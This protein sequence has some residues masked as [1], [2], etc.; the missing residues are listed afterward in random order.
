MCRAVVCP[1]RLVAH[2]PG[3]SREWKCF[4]WSRASNLFIFSRWEE[5][6]LMT[7]VLAMCPMWNWWSS[8]QWQHLAPICP[9]VLSLSQ[10]IWVWLS[11]TELFCSIP[12]CAV[13][14]H[15]TLNI[16]VVRGRLGGCGKEEYRMGPEIMWSRLWKNWKSNWGWLIWHCLL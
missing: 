12:S 3:W 5:F 7:A 6:T 11:T 4:W 9:L 16:T 10:A 8:S 2:F 14:K 13:E 15:W 1:R